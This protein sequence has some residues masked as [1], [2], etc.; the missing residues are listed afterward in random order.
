MTLLGTAEQV[1]C[2]ARKVFGSQTDTPGLSVVLV[3]EDKALEAR[4]RAIPTLQ[5]VT[6]LHLEYTFARIGF[7]LAAE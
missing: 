3:V 4:S 5:Q 6:P 1:E 2:G 7:L